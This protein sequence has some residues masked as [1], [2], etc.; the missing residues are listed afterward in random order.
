MALSRFRRALSSSETSTGVAPER[1]FSVAIRLDVQHKTAET[2]TGVAP[3]RF[4]S[5]AIR[6]DFQQKTAETTTG[7][8]PERFSIF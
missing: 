5:V 1:F 8:A 7:V 6:L 4:I 3:E 2:T